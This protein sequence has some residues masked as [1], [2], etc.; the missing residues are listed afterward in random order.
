MEKEKAMFGA[1]CFWCVEEDFQKAPGVVSTRVGYS[2]GKSENP[3]Y[4]QV[5]SG[6]TGHT[7]VTLVEFDPKVI[8]YEQLLEVFFSIHDP[9]TLNRQGPDIGVQYRSVI[10]YF[11][12][13]QRKAAEEVKK[14]LQASGR[15]PKLIVTAIEPAQ[16]FYKAEEYHQNYYCKLRGS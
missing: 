16:A 2:G 1:G 9:T 10:F 6:T 7:E 11:D 5:C 12:D 4:S 15:F 13:K 8:S 14:K 3:T